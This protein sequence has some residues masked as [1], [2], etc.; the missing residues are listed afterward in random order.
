MKEDIK[1]E[2]I[3]CY[4]AMREN[5]LECASDY[6]FSEERF[7]YDS[8]NNELYYKMEKLLCEAG[9]TNEDGDLL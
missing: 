1:E 2:I 7:D 6:D 4:L 9:Y 3:Q 8:I 5:D